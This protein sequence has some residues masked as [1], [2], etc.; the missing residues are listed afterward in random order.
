MNNA[1]RKFI[2]VITHAVSYSDKKLPLIDEILSVFMDTLNPL[3]DPTSYLILIFFEGATFFEVAS[4]IR[5]QCEPK[6]E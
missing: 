5:I 3:L 2:D 4:A 6:V 1:L